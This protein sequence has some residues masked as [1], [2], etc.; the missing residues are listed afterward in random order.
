MIRILIIDDEREVIE[1]IEVLISSRDDMK[2]VGSLQNVHGVISYIEA[3]RRDVV[4]MNISMPGLSGVET[5]KQIKDHFVGAPEIVILTTFDLNQMVLS[6][7][8]AGAQGFILK[9]D[10]PQ[11]LYSAIITAHRGDA[12]ISP[13]MLRNLV[14]SLTA[15]QSQ[16][17]HVEVLSSKCSSRELDILKLVVHGLANADIASLLY[18]SKNTIRS[19]VAHLHDRLTVKSR[20]ALVAK[21]G[22]LVE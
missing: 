22:E 6:A 1:S 11:D 21:G 16:K 12:L 15:K 10:P 9:S 13:K 14:T 7:L 8:H 18:I 3:L 5:T 4:L 2:V 17:L 20:A 19:H